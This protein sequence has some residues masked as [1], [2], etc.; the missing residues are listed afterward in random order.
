MGETHN[1]PI[2][3]E[4]IVGRKDK[5]KLFCIRIVSLEFVT[6][7]EVAGMKGARQMLGEMIITEC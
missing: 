3:P 5:V 4:T 1:L 7:N 2:T 6:Y